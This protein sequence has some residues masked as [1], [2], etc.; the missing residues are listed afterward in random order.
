MAATAARGRP[1]LVVETVIVLGLSLGRSAVY[2]ILNIINR[3]TLPDLPLAEQSSTM[4][5]SVTPDRPGLDLAYQLANNLF[6]F[7]HPML[8]LYL[9]W[10]IWSPPHA[11]W[12]AIGL[13]GRHVG[14]DVVWGSGLAAAILGPALGFYLLARQIGINTTV[15]MADLAPAWWTI[16]MYV[17]AAFMNGFLEEVVMIGYLF[18]RWRQSGWHPV[19]IVVISAL[20]R[21]M[22]HLYQGFG[23]F[24]SNLVFGLLLGWLYTRT[25]RLWPLVIAHALID[26]AA[27]VGYALLAD[28]FDWL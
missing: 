22:Y 2:S 18:T 21:G 13:D 9:L 23:G 25:K 7:F 28:A 24:L 11:P 14:R 6:P 16:P 8:A 1:H 10:R 20:I 3:L 4:N 15:V 19:P 12:R 17:L 27:F 5:S 26:V